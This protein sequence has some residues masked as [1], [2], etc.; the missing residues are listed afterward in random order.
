MTRPTPLS[1]DRPTP[2]SHLTATFVQTPDQPAKPLLL[3]VSG[4]GDEIFVIFWELV[5]GTRPLVWLCLIAL[6]AAVVG[7]PV[8]PGEPCNRAVLWVSGLWFCY[9]ICFEY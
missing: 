5:K 6:V 4:G 3:S 9:H 1:R 8:A 2:F 7:L